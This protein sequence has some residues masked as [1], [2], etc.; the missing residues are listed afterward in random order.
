MR[1][2][3]AFSGNTT[4]FMGTQDVSARAVA[5]RGSAQT[6][7]PIPVA[8][9][10]SPGGT[11]ANLYGFQVG[12]WST[13]FN[14]THNGGEFGW[15]N[16]D[17]SNSANETK[18]E[19]TDPNC[20]TRVGQTLGTPGAQTAVDTP[21]N[22]RFGVY[23]NGGDPS[24]DTPDFTGYAYS[25]TNW[26][27]DATLCAG[28]PGTLPCK[29]YNGS[30]PAGADP[31]AANFVTKRAAFAS[32]DDTGTDIKDASQILYAS[33]NALNGF[34][35]LAT[36]GTT[37]QHYQYGS[38]RRIASV[39][40]LDSTNSVID[41]MCVLMLAPMTGPND[42]NNIEILGL[43]SDPTSPCTTSGLP[44]GVAGPLV[45]VLVR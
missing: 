44:G 40:V 33:K 35:F 19:L 42:D 3:A 24:V 37:G 45:P 36:P 11:A 20:N 30:K 7:C 9:K 6:T 38:S 25:P 31:T 13:I 23:K 32:L 39:P 22:I 27:R 29:A 10:A 28:M 17:G 15:Y 14:K 18:N 34:K 43:A 4:T 21:W 1:A 26:P 8:V 12:Q 16:L 41:Y 5:K 2:L